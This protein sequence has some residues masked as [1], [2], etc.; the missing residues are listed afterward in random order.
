MARKTLLC[1]CV[2]EENEWIL[3]RV[4]E[5][6]RHHKERNRKVE[7]RPKAECN[8]TDTRGE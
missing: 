5:C 3:V 4:K 2:Y 1:G 6:E 8:R 7:Y